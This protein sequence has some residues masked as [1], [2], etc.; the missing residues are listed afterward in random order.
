MT[1]AQIDYTVADA[2]ATITLNRPDQ[3]NAFTQVMRR[4]LVDALD[5]V[6]ADDDVRAVILTGSGKHFCVGADLSGNT[7]D[8]PFAYRGEGQSDTRSVPDTING[9]PRD[10]G[11]VVT[12]RLAAMRTPTIAAINGA[13]VGVGATMTLPMDIRIAADSSRFGLVFARRGI[14]PEAASNWFLPRVVG[15]AQAMEW[16]VTGRI[17]P[18]EEALAGGLVSRVVP[19][20]DLLDVARGIAA[21]IRDSTS[22]VSIAVARQMLWS[23]LS[24]PSP[25]WAHERESLIMRDLKRGPDAAEGV[26][27]FLEKRLP[28]FPAKVS[29]DYPE[30][31]PTWPEQPDHVQIQSAST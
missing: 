28:S 15:I 4:E 30:H 16:V 12:L 18:A 14:M 29:R 8:Q 31:A 23:S 25:W 3:G 20:D 17:F 7:G 10:G 6:D 22:S 11:G 1:F 19:R 2:I 13:A 9:V 27:S 26:A 5:L 21:E 24:E